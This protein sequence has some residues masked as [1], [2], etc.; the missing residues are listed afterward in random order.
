M[1]RAQCPGC[2]ASHYQYKAILDRYAE[3][4]P[5]TVKYLVKDYP[6]NSRCNVYVA[7]GVGHPAPCEAAVVVRLATER[8]KREPMI[9][10]A[11]AHQEATADIVRDRAK[12][13]LGITD[14]AAEYARLIPEIKRDIADGGALTIPVTP[15]YYINGVRALTPDNHW[16]DE[17]YFDYAIRYELNNGTLGPSGSGSPAKK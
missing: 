3:T 14:F 4:M 6:L 11:F 9:D 15:T 16:L 2:K 5:G 1:R 17:K 8:S 13:E 10:W 12:T 7:A